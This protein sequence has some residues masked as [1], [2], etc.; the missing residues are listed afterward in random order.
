MSFFGELDKFVSNLIKDLK[1][2]E[3]ARLRSCKQCS[4]FKPSDK[5]AGFCTQSNNYILSEYYAQGCIYYSAEG[6]V[7][8]S[9]T[10]EEREEGI[11]SL[12]DRIKKVDLVDL[13]TTIGTIQNISSIDLI[14]LIGTISE[15]T[16]I[17]KIESIESGIS[18]DPYGLTSKD[19]VLDKLEFTYG[20]DGNISIIRGYEGETQKFTL[21][22]TWDSGSLTQI[23][24][25]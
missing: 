18:F 3:V 6:I 21:T 17:K 14:D 8:G 11:R 16:T 7:T 12:L 23:V 2:S 24:R 10:T 20:G 19:K 25:T 4:Y 15:V 9:A 13:I 22:F 1:P 5:Y